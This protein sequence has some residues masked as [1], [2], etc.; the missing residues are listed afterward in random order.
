MRVCEFCD[1]C[2]YDDHFGRFLKYVKTKE[3]SHCI[4]NTFLAHNEHVHC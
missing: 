3:T 2:H 4:T 1:N